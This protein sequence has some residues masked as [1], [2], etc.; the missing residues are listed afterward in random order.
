MPVLSTLGAMSA[1]GFRAWQPNLA[2]FEITTSQQELNLET[3]LTGLGWGGG[4]KVELTIAS[5]VYIWSD[6][7][8]TAGLIIPSSLSD[9]L[10]II[11]NGYIIG[12]KGGNGGAYGIQ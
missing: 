6:S 5:G 9:R 7:T 8:S 12:R 10:T 11:N 3:Y 1:R 2:K 4:S